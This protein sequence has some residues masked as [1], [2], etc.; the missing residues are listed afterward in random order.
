MPKVTAVLMGW[1]DRNTPFLS[2]DTAK[3]K[4][5]PESANPSMRTLPLCRR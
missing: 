3:T 1:F 2:G 5:I 4:I